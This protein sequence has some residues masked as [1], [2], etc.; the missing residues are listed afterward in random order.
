[1]QLHGNMITDWRIKL[2]CTLLFSFTRQSTNNAQNEHK[3]LTSR[4]RGQVDQYIFAET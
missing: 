2:R 1:M 4:Y 3:Y